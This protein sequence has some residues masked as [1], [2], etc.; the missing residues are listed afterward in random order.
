[1]EADTVDTQFKAQREAVF[2]Q[3]GLN[4]ADYV[5]EEFISS[6]ETGSVPRD[7]PSPKNFFDR[8]KKK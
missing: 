3:F 8:F 5:R 1:M 4:A 6:P 2:K 7:K